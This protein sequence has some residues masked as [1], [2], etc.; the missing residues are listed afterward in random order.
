MKNKEVIIIGGGLAGSEAAYQLARRGFDVILYEMRPKT[1][2]PAHKTDK[3]AE[4]VCSNSLGSED[5]NTSGG[6]LKR[7]LRMLDSLLLKKA[8]ESKVPA[9]HALAVDRQKFSE[10]VTEELLNFKNIKIIREEIKQIPGD[11]PVII[12]TGPLTTRALS[13]EIMKFTGRQNL[14]FYDA[15]SP[16]VE[17]SSIN[18]DIVFKASRYEKGGEDYLNAPFTEEEYKR[19]YNEL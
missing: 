10:S 13:V 5:E 4:I 15:T 17:A 11:K 1:M 16:I 2:T 12:A 8:E 9:G 7:E 6:V 3:F 19:F 14:F 18:R